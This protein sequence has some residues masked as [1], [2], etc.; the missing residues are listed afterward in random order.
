[1]QQN[2]TDR[3]QCGHNFVCQ[4]KLFNQRIKKHKLCKKKNINYCYKKE[5]G[6][7][8]YGQIGFIEPL[9]KK[10]VGY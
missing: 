1:M 8:I 2:S 4:H 9:L 7:D 3:I 10:T 5:D 6:V